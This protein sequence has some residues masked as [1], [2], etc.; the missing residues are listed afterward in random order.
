VTIADLIGDIDPIKAAKGGHELGSEYT[1]HYDCCARQ[2]RASLPSTN[3]LT[4]PA[5]SRLA[6]S[7]I[8]QKATS[9]LRATRCACRWMSRWSSAPIPRTYTARGKDHHSVER[10]ASVP[11]FAL[12]I[13]RPLKRASPSR[14]GSLDRA[15]RSS[16]A[17]PT[18]LARS[19]SKS[20]SSPARQAHRQAL[21]RQPTTCQSAPQRMLISNA[22][23]RAIRSGEKLVVPRVSDIYAAMPP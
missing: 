15:H 18:S 11:R 21:R 6:C 9:R 16:I 12:T 3:C 14:A 19:S 8:M 4:L 10:P 20:P 1:V 22:E 2:S 7:N 5:K 13:P 17:V 23:R